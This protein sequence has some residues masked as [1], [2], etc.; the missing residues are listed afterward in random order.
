MFAAAVAAI[1]DV[2]GMSDD[3]AGESLWFARRNFKPTQ[4]KS[5]ISKTKSPYQTASEYGL[6][7]M[8][9]KF[10]ALKRVLIPISAMT[11]MKRRCIGQKPQGSKIS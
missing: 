3:L 10:A 7:G 4:T 6:Q 1:G 9:L 2:I 5:E 8:R 11:L